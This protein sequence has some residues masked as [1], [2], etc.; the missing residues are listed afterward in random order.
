MRLKL[1]SIRREIVCEEL[2]E[3]ERQ[4]ANIVMKRAVSSRDKCIQ[5]SRARKR[6]TKAC[7]LSKVR[8]F[9]ILL[10]EDNGDTE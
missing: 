7:K 2:C 8:S 4:N 9:N 1:P 6:R 3:N 10:N 5:S